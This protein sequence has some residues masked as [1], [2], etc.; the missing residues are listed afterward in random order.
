MARFPDIT[1]SLFEQ[2]HRR[3]VPAMKNLGP[4]MTR[5]KENSDL[6]DDKEVR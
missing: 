4:Y 2:R 1:I 6:C 5:C 3:R